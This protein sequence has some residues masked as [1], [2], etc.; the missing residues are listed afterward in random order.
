MP[1]NRGAPMRKDD[2]KRR[3]NNIQPDTCR[4]IKDDIK[5]GVPF[6]HADKTWYVKDGS[7]YGGGTFRKLLLV[8]KTFFYKN[9]EKFGDYKDVMPN[10]RKEQREKQKEAV[11]V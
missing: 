5:P 8:G 9:G 11:A 4:R 6:R 1:G 3:N 10:P 2:M 7:V